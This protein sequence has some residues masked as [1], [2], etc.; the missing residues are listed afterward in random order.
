MKEII[1]CTSK[2][3]K[4]IADMRLCFPKELVRKP[5]YEIA[6]KAELKQQIVSIDDLINTL[7]KLLEIAAPRAKTLENCWQRSINIATQFKMVAGDTPPGQ[8]HWYETHTHS[9]VIHLTPLDIAQEFHQQ[10]QELNSAKIFTSA[11]LA[12]KSDFQYFTQQIGLKDAKCLQ[13]PSSYDYKT[14]ARLYI[15]LNIPDPS[16]GDFLKTIVNAACPVIKAAGG[17][18]F[19][20]FTSH[21]ALRQAAE[22][23]QGKINFPILMQGQMPKSKLL[24]QFRKLGNAVL[25]ATSSFWEGVDVKGE[26]LSCVI[27]DKL[28]FAAPSDPILKAQI[29]AIKAAGGDPFTDFQ[30]NQA[31]I[32]LKQGAGRLIRDEQD[33]GVLMICDPRIIYKPYGKAFIASLPPMPITRSL[34]EIEEFFGECLVN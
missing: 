15:P 5:W 30:L 27:I 17:R 24:E 31:V 6:N 22:L 16:A 12:V 34:A 26:A 19:F 2:I 33:R 7:R 20:L 32:A 9:F 14:I 3:Q 1:D 18:T 8:I 28:P 4:T 11:T 21:Y 23:L 10:I 13:L 25:L 29:A